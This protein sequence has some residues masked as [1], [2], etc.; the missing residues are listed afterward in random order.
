MSE[1]VPNDTP[2]IEHQDDEVSLLDLAVVLAKHK[3]L[4]LGL[5]LAA[6]LLAAIVSLLMTPIYTGTARILPPQQNQSNAAALLGQLGF[7]GGIAGGALGIKNPNELYVGMLKSRT[8]ADGLISRFDLKE[9][10]DSDTLDD[11]RRQLDKRSRIASGKDGIITIEVEDE[12]PKQ[13]A[14]MANAYVEELDR[15][16][17]TLA[18]TEAAQRRLFFE[19]QVRLAK[20]QLADAEVALKKTQQATGLIKLD[21][22]GRAIIEA[23]ARLRAEI[24]AREVQ[25]TAM[26]TFATERNPEYVRLTQELAGMRVQLAKLE[27]SA[28]A[29]EGDVLMP[30]GNVPEA[31]L[32]YV[33]KLRD[34]KYFETMFELIAKQYELA[35]LDEAKD[36]SIIQLLD[37]AVEPERRSRPKR[38]LIT[39]TAAIASMLAAV[40]V[41]FFREAAERTRR[42]PLATKR[43]IELRN[44]L[45]WR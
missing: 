30:T 31:G 2:P 23:V 16:N 12:D 34:V 17:D 33:R 6:A 42:D 14:A 4:V 38:A 13:A 26:R 3:K 10:Y 44:Y 27:K 22:Q 40:L 36:L 24:A 18:V 15:L 32:E 21:D 37:R 8:V 39:L 41:A 45:R 43:M 25:L 29:T 5:P 1:P 19:K 11:A 28:P 9:R 7:A 20:E 35:R